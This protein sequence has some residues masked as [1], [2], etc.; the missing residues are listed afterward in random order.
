MSTTANRA[1]DINNNNKLSAGFPSNDISKL[2]KNG[3]DSHEKIFPAM[4]WFGA[5][6][7][8]TLTKLVYFKPIGCDNKWAELLQLKHKYLVENLT[9]EKAGV[10]DRHLE[11]NDVEMN[12]QIGCL[13]F[14]RFP[15]SEMTSFIDIVKS[16]DFHSPTINACVTGGGAYKYEKEFKQAK[17]INLRRFDEL[18][19]LIHGIHFV[20][21]LNPSTECYFFSDS[22]QSSLSDRKQSFDFRDHPYPYL[23]VNVGSGVSMLV[24]RSQT[25]FRRV[26][27]SSLG[28]GTFLGLSCLLTGCNTFEEAID[29]ASAGDHSNVDKLVKDIYGG[30]YQRFG[31]SGNTVASSFGNMWKKEERDKV[32]KEDLAK[33]GLVMITNNIGSIAR[34]VAINEKIERIVFVGNFLRV[35]PISMKL[36]SYA[37][38]YW[39][40]GSMKALF[41]EH[42]GYFGAVGCLVQEVER[43]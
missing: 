15:T 37:M 26:C 36:L 25:D 31:L 10:L 27:G 22:D 21:K 40:C 7:G 29:L 11:I 35:N 16:N 24:V 13:H 43:E 42:E 14:I 33:A 20:Q 5:D 19:S 4:P 8:G 6:I 39:S 32:S 9:N 28:G 1:V 30:D 18:D 34:M 41:L 17:T 23:A 2:T 38:D 3:D 12:G